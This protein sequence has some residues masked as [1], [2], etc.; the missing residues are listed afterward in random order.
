MKESKETQQEKN[1]YILELYNKEQKDFE[2]HW[3][4]KELGTTPKEFFEKVDEYVK[5][6]GIEPKVWEE[7]LKE[8]K[9][10]IETQINEQNKKYKKVDFN[11]FSGIKI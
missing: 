3:I 9:K 7:K 2:S 5:S 1:Q 10:N 8:A 11:N 4:W 6:S